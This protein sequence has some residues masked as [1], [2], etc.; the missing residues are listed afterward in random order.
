MVRAVIYLL[1][2]INIL[3]SI[4]MEKPKVM[5]SIDGKMAMFT[6]VNSSTV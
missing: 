4:I 2:E 6:L 5:D 3:V 1:L